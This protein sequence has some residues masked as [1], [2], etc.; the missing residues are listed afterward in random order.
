MSPNSR[1][2]T[3]AVRGGGGRGSSRT[4]PHNF[5][6]H[7]DQYTLAL[8]VPNL[9]TLLV[10]LSPHIPDSG[11][12]HILLR[13]S[14]LPEVAH[15]FTP[16]PVPPISLSQA[17][18]TPLTATDGGTLSFPSRPPLLTYVLPSAH[19]AHNLWSV[20][21]LIGTDG[22]ATFTPTSVSFSARDSP[23]PFLTGSKSSTDTLWSLHIPPPTPPAC[24]HLSTPV[25][26]PGNFVPSPIFYPVPVPGIFSRYFF[27]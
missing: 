1:P 8:R 17:N 26:V 11:A 25:P 13:S 2:H 16:S 15:L 14:S 20:S 19:L 21:A 18:G 24:M 27:Q 10:A 7:K 3:A 5:L 6:P 9:P 4:Y 23:T 12:S 22:T